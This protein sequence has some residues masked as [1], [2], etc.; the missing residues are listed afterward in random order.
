MTT[1]PPPWEL[2]PGPADPALSS[3]FQSYSGSGYGKVGQ[4]TIN[5]APLGTQGT[6]PAPGPAPQ[7]GPNLRTYLGS[8]G[9]MYAYD[10][11]TGISYL[12]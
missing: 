11:A 3:T 5:T 4:G 6:P 7:S 9:K 2:G 1:S 8:D 10:P 12:L